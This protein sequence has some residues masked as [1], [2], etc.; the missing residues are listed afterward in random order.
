[1]PR[2]LIMICDDD[3][4]L[5]RAIATRLE[6]ERYQAVV[7]RDGCTAL[8]IAMTR[9]PDLLVFDINM[10][11][12]NGFSVHERL[13]HM[14]NFALRPLIFMSGEHGDWLERSALEHGAFAFLRKPFELS[15]LLALVKQATGDAP[16]RAA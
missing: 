2:K 5:A 16:I 13:R 8:E 6:H 3:E 14:A 15:E 7:A 12:G 4:R 11:A 9:C 10:P 1:M